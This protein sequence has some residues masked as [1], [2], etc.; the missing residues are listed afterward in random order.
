MVKITTIGIMC[1]VYQ[2]NCSLFLLSTHSVVGILCWQLPCCLCCQQQCQGRPL[3]N[4]DSAAADFWHP[5]HRM[6]QPN[7]I[8]ISQFWSNWGGGCFVNFY[9]VTS[10]PTGITIYFWYMW[11]KNVNYREPDWNYGTALDWHAGDPG[12]ILHAAKFFASFFLI[13]DE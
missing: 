5:M 3:P 8:N 13:I 1:N 10:R 11:L 12:S 9:E 6:T 7:S 2:K 4:I